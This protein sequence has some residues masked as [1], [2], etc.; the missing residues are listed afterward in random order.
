MLVVIKTY[1]NCSEKLEIKT[2]IRSILS[3]SCSYTWGLHMGSGTMCHIGVRRLR[4]TSLKLGV[5]R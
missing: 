5:E 3:F 2:H 1:T 4:D